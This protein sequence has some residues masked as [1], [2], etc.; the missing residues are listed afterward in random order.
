VTALLLERSFAKGITGWTPSAEECPPGGG[1]YAWS[2]RALRGRETSGWSEPLFFAVLRD[3]TRADQSLQE[4]ATEVDAPVG[5]R[6][7]RG[8]KR[9]VFGPNAPSGADPER[10]RQRSLGGAALAVGS[11]GVVEAVSFVGNGQG[12]TD[13]TWGNID[14]VPA[15][16]ADGD[17]N[18]TISCDWAGNH[19]V[20]SGYDGGAFVQCGMTVTCTS[21]KVTA[22]VKVNTIP[23]GGG[24][25]P[26]V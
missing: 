1:S 15:D 6:G 2:V 24:C 14:G 5:S 19:Y 10:L 20:S 26:N 13:L 9:D 12:L 11:S 3:S 4:D 18:P 16:L 21:G 7:S 23:G 8:V 25:P 22:M 17:A